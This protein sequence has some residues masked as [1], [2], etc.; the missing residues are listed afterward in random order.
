M[1]YRVYC[2]NGIAAV[3]SAL[4]MVFLRYIILNTLY[5]CDKSIVIIIIVL[6]KY[7]PQG[8]RSK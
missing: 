5:K 2:N 7:T 4:K 3:L 8:S 6:I 1:Y